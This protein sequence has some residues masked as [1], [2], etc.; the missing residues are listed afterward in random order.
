MVRPLNGP[1]VRDAILN[2]GKRATEGA[3]YFWGKVT[4]GVQYSTKQALTVDSGRRAGVGTFKASKDFTR[5]DV[6]YG[7]LCCVSIGSEAVSGILVSW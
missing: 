6:M 4:K 7:V 2:Q 5:G 3:A 1:A